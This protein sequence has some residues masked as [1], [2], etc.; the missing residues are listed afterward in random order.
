M[1]CHI[2]K[3]R[4]RQPHGSCGWQVAV[5][6]N[7]QISDISQLGFLHVINVFYNS[8]IKLFV[9]LMP[10]SS[11]ACIAILPRGDISN[12]MGVAVGRWLFTSDVQIS[13]INQLLLSIYFKCVL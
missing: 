9:I 12:P 6:F 3:G 1:R 8:F 13:D 2:P 4:P 7:V 10:F 5:Q 11:L